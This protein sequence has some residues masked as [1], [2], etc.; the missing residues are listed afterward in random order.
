MGLLALGTALWG[1]SQPNSK[2]RRRSRR[3]FWWGIGS[4][5]ASFIGVLLA[6]LNVLGSF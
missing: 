4:I 1:A 3:V 2:Y 5:L 6:A